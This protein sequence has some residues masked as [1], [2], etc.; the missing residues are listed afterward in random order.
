MFA[1]Q[2][3]QSTVSPG[4]LNET[5]GKVIQGR[6]YQWRMPREKD[7]GDDISRSVA[8]N[9]WKI[10]RWF[11]K[12]YQRICVD[13]FLPIQKGGSELSPVFQ[14][15]VMYVLLTAVVLIFVAAVLVISRKKK[16]GKP[17]VAEPND[18]ATRCCG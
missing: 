8:L 7:T 15:K 5:I 1:Y 6:E 18:D 14:A 11:Q 12:W 16:S 2:S 13:S 17:T 9:F 4:R 10:Y 3:A